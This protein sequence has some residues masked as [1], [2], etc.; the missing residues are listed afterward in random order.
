M[1]KDM[2]RVGGRLSRPAMPEEMKHPVILAKDFHIADL[3]LR[4][5]W[6][7][8]TWWSQP[9]ATQTES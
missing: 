5:S 6:R 7:G 4:H 9:Y 2:L 8:G 1:D 3:I